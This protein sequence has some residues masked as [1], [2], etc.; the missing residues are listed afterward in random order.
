MM[1]TAAS[2]TL[3]TPMLKQ[4]K[5]IKDTQRDAIL[6]FRLGDFYEMFLDDA[7]IASKELELTLTGRGKDE[8]RIPMCGIPYHAAEN[9]IAKLVN[10]GYKVAICEQVED[11]ALAKGLTRREV[12]KVITPGTVFSQTV[13]DEKENNYLA[14]VCAIKKSEEIGMAFIDIT[15]GE[16]QLLKTSDQQMALDLLLQRN[17]KEVLVDDVLKTDL[18]EAIC[19]NRITMTSIDQSESALK[20]H[21]KIHA[22]SAFGIEGLQTALP[23]AW[24]VLD[25]VIKTQKNSVPQI[26]K[27]MKY[28]PKFYM[29]LDHATV[30]NLELTES[31]FRRN[32][33]GTLF[34][35]MDHTKT[36]M[37]GRKLKSWIKSPL[38]DVKE[39]NTRL[40]AV[41]GLVHD[42]LSKEELRE[43]LHQV[44]DL[45]RLIS[46]IASDHNNPR[47]LMALKISLA[48]M[49]DMAAILQH[50]TAARLQ[51]FTHFF[52]LFKQETSPFRQIIKVID[53][54]IIDPPPPNLRDGAVI[55]QGYSEELDV[56]ML[57]FV[58]IKK[59]IADLESLERA[60]TG[61]KSLKVRFNRVFGYYIEIPNTHKEAIPE[62]YIRKQTM[63][64]AE[65]YITPELKEKE[66]ILLHGEEKQR[67]LE[68][69]L[70]QELVDNI[71]KHIPELQMLAD[72]V[73]EI[74]V[75][76]SLATIAQKQAYT[77]PQFTDD[78]DSCLQIKNGRHP[79]LERNQ[80]KPYV[81]NDIN[82][83]KD[84]DRFIIITGPNMAGKSTVMRQV[85]LC[86]I[87][88]QMGSFVPAESMRLSLVDKLFT[89]IGAMDNLYAGQSTFMVEMLETASILNNATQNSL[90]LLDEIGRG[91]S[92]FDGMS[93][94]GAITEWI[95]T[96]IK[97][98]AMFATHYHELTVLEKSLNNL[99]N[100]SMQI[101][102]FQD[103]VTFNYKLIP[104]PADKSYGIHVAKMAGLPK[105]VIKKAEDL[106]A[107]FEKEG[108]T[109]LRDQVNRDQ[110]S[111][112]N[113]QG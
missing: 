61:I 49:T 56:L 6:F 101:T 65:R 11:P 80:S 59:W 105:E 23:A 92:T 15:T 60:K 22:L 20:T 19:V 71:K 44:Y 36:A 99:S 113:N 79:V 108:I 40:D 90:I 3:D 17:V 75:Y 77:R 73:A 95:C 9:Y 25:Y 14:A 107:G 66:N 102:E 96:K 37:G 74:D 94:A 67:A 82:L 104:G 76:Q 34:W 7:A 100:F 5:A 54:A 91:T 55:K 69:R 62:H 1:N 110:L 27:L 112:F 28:E 52:E 33:T 70:Y 106:L 31:Y 47:D 18:P 35:V 88:A 32:K 39:I 72:I 38:L 21:F 12:V 16:F 4:Y 85:G 13:L 46:R 26:T 57:S 24:S 53:R 111:L 29:Q 87:M 42:V 41:E 45:E 30:M 84:K 81:P 50:Q 48:G 2:P 68:V 43:V 78:E 93:I 64:N 97:S 58:D 8:N 83:T 89:R 10:R 51:E 103:H 63:T 86:T 109:Y 98:R